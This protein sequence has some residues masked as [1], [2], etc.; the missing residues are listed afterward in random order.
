[1]M[2]KSTLPPFKEVQHYIDVIVENDTSPF[3]D[4]SDYLEQVHIPEEKSLLG[5]KIPLN[6]VRIT[7]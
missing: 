2:M 3:D 5:R 1:M 4:D 7:E 6:T